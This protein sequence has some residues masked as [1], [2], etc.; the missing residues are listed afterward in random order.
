M[1]SVAFTALSTQ[2]TSATASAVRFFH[3]LLAWKRGDLA[4]NPTQETQDH[5]PSRRRGN[6]VRAQAGCGSSRSRWL[7]SERALPTLRRVTLATTVAA[8]SRFTRATTARSAAPKASVRGSPVNRRSASLAATATQTAGR[9]SAT[10]C[11]VRR[12][13]THPTRLSR[14]VC[15]APLVRC[16]SSIP[17]W[18]RA[19]LFMTAARAR[20]RARAAG[21]PRAQSVCAAPLRDH[22]TP[23]AL[24]S[25]AGARATARAASMPR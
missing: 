25:G 11:A 10:G 13:W 22:R 21:A 1:R 16:R 14:F 8:R 4:A 20:T 3:C 2:R 12:C 19:A 5:T 17:R 6:G 24:A 23:R 7:Q 9:F 15:A 18:T